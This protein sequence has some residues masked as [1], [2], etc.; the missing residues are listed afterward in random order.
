M[1]EEPPSMRDFDYFDEAQQSTGLEDVEELF[2]E[3]AGQTG[4]EAL[5]REY[6][7]RKRRTLGQLLTALAFFAVALWYLAGYSD[8]IAYAFAAPREPL[9]VGDVVAVEHDDLVHNQYVEL[10]GV[11]MHRGLVQKLVRGI[12]LGRE[13]LHYFEL[14]GS[15]GVFIEVPPERGTEFT[16]FVRV[17]GRVVDPKRDRSYDPLLKEYRRRYFQERRPAER[18]LQ[19]GVAPGEGK[20]PVLW[21]TGVLAAIALLNLYSLVRVLRL[22]RA[23]PTLA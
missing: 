23:R 1:A 13:E 22:R 15:R 10:E 12:G 2:E 4:L 17:A 16:T 18:I 9:R 8:W 7:R 11:T 5:V 19:V 6:D 14:S 20:G 3:D 21:A